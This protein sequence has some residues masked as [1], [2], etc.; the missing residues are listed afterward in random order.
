M[1]RLALVAALALLAGCAGDAPPATGT[2]NPAV[3][4]PAELP[5]SVLDSVAVDEGFQFSAEGAPSALATY[6]LDEGGECIA[7]PDYVVRLTRVDEDDASAGRT[8]ELV[9]RTEGTSPFD[10]CDD[11]GEIELPFRPETDTFVA[12]DRTV[13]WRLRDVSGRDLLIGY[14]FE[15][16]AVIFEEPAT[17]PVQ[18]DDEGLTYGGPPETM[19]SLDALDAAGVACPEAAA[20]FEAGERVAISRRLRFTF[21]EGTTADTGEARCFV[22]PDA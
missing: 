22:Q 2:D 17:S 7:Y 9:A 21:A 12:L 10:Q 1:T 8:L 4:T 19:A 20:W 6:A 15:A 11:E 3:T 18:K 5:A 14:D 16:D 13:V